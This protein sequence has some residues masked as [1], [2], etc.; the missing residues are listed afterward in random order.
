MI[1][2]GLEFL[3][4]DF[5]LKNRFLRYL[6][7]FKVTAAG[8]VLVIS[9]LATGLMGSGSLQIPLYYLFCAFSALIGVSIL[10]GFFFKPRVKISGT[11]PA[12]TSAGQTIKGQMILTNQNPRR[13]LYDLS[14]GLFQLPPELS[15]IDED[16]LILKLTPGESA[17][18]SIKI[19][20]VKRG[21]YSLSKWTPY[22]TFPFNFFRTSGKAT[23]ASSLLVLPAFHALESVHLPIGSR[24]QPGGVSLTSNIGESTEF[25]GNREYR[26]GDPTNRI[27]FRSWARLAKPV[28]KE[29][30]EEYYCRIALVLDTFIPKVRRTKTKGFPELEAA[31]SFTAAIADAL[32]RGEYI[33]DLFAAGPNLYVFRAGRHTAH[34]DNVL[35]ILACMDACRENPFDV[36]G[37]A[38]AEELKTI[39]TV[40]CVFLDWDKNRESL[41]RAAVEAGCSVKLILIRDE[42]STVPLDEAEKW[43][44]S[45]SSFSVDAVQNGGIE[46]L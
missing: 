40:V 30:Q 36:V 26:S 5:H 22:T 2:E 12:K 39:S 29:Y 19:K 34:F 45:V 25:I 42:E 15:Q 4:Q 9:F 28:V 3:N 32:C 46:S 33:I 41:V 17:P 21:L 38:I 6:W 16:P 13:N 18:V 43:A 24:Y 35:E 8:K 20:P 10:A 11:F 44:T 23:P 14:T 1:K 27:D 7:Q 31:I 37:P